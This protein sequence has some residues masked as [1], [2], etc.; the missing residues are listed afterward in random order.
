MALFRRVFRIPAQAVSPEYREMI[1]H[2]QAERDQAHR[3]AEQ[4][5]RQLYDRLASLRAETELAKRLAQDRLG[6]LGGHGQ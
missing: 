3:Q 4:T 5:N 1:E 2:R 6:G